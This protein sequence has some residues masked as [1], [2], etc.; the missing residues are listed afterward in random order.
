MIVRMRHTFERQP[1]QSGKIFHALAAKH[2][3]DGLVRIKHRL[4]IIISRTNE[5]AA[6][7][8]AAKLFCRSDDLFLT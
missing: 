7:H 2:G 3:K 5:K 8:E 6:G 1:R 4:R